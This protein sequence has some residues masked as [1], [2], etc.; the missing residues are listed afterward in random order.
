MRECLGANTIV[1]LLEGVIDPSERTGAVAHLDGCSVCRSLTAQ[2]AAS[3]GEKRQPPAPLLEAGQA[4]GRYRIERILGVGAMGVVY[5]GHDAQLGRR[6]ALKLLRAAAPAGEE[7]RGRLF[8]EAKALASLSHPNV[9]AVHD[10][11]LEGGRL[12]VAMELVEGGTLREWLHARERS[13]REIAGVFRA[14]AVGLQAAHKAGLVHR[15]FKPDNVLVGNDGRVRVADFGLA[16][17]AGDESEAGA[18]VGTPGYMA[19]EQLAGRRAD[20]R[21]DQF[22]FC[23]ALYEAACGVRPFAG[24]EVAELRARIETGEM[25]APIRRPPAWLKRVALRGLERDPAR[26]FADLREL[27]AALDAGLQRPQRIAFAAGALALV[28]LV[29]ASGAIAWRE[30]AQACSSS[31]AWG[32]LWSDEQR[33]A[34]R[35]AFLRAKFPADGAFE[36][37]DRALADF[38]RDWLREHGQACA[39]AR[40]PGASEAAVARFVCLLDARSAAESKVKLLGTASVASVRALLD[41]AGG[42]PRL[43]RCAEGAANLRPPPPREEDRRAFAQHLESHFAEI[44]LLRWTDK[45]AGAALARAVLA[46][47]VALG[48]KPLVVKATFQAARF[49]PDLQKRLDAYRRAANLAVESGDD[50]TAADAWT[51]L[52][53]EASRRSKATEARSWYGLADAAARR[54]GDEV[55]RA[56]VLSDLAEMEVQIE[57]K[58]E[59]AQRHIDESAAVEMAATGRLRPHTRRENAQALIY[60]EGGRIADAVAVFDRFLSEVERLY[61]PASDVVYVYATNEASAWLEIDRYDKALPL[62]ERSLSVA[63]AIGKFT[64]FALQQTARALRARRDYAGA[65]AKDREAWDSMTEGHDEDVWIRHGLACDLLGLGRAAEAVPFAEIAL[66]TDEREDVEPGYAYVRAWLG[67][68]LARALHESGRDRPR[69]QALAARAA[70]VYRVEAEK[71]GGQYRLGLLE[72]EAWRRAHPDPHEPERA[73]DLQVGK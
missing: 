47:A 52:G 27:I 5:A 38:K 1:E 58:L 63:R 34:T 35:A 60:L 22:A 31:E 68:T 7:P 24:R 62:L 51:A 21:S 50:E 67:F 15:D 42:L 30:R 44:E 16:L 20:A 14:A 25:T 43:D 29:A 59:D 33:A 57:R 10:V 8:R 40:A 45:P 23:A 3:T 65:L 17:A 19:P 11:A 55:R 56:D 73:R 32:A 18:L 26:R 36:D 6:V 49:E 64:W 66:A 9:L 70:D 71:Y 39:A 46:E 13:W 37:I 72:I 69:A 41:T 54:L 12:L 4:L 2:V 48:H 61:G 28:A 53:L